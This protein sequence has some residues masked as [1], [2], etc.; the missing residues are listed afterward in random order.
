MDIKE[1]VVE[2]LKKFNN[3]EERYNH[4]PTFNAIIESLSMG[5][6]K[7]QMM[8]ILFDQLETYKKLYFNSCF[9]TKI[10]ISEP[11]SE[12]YSVTFDDFDS[13]E[14]AKVFIDWYDE[15][16]CQNSDMWLEEW[17]DLSAAYI[18]SEQFKNEFI[19]NNI[20]VPL[21]LYYKNK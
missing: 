18:N 5:A 11:I 14:Q 9:Q 2:L 7:F 20:T 13:K 8:E 17:S 21:K 12:K 10:E 6:D 1:S 3:G 15:Q 19:R 4:D 16:G